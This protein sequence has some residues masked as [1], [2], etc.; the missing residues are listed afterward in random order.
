MQGYRMPLD[1]L[2]FLLEPFIKDHV[3]SSSF[4]GTNVARFRQPSNACA[5]AVGR[6]HS[7]FSNAVGRVHSG[8]YPRGATPSK[9]CLSESILAI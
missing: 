9:L 7:G 8:T 3:R 1:H 6:M 4:P 2:A 5:S